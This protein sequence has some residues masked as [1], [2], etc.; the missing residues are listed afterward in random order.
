MA[1]VRYKIEEKEVLVKIVENAAAAAA[2]E[3]ARLEA[4]GNMT[5]DGIPF[6]DLT[7]SQAKRT[8]DTIDNILKKLRGEFAEA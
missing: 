2:E 6:S 3:V 5:P 8:V 4:L 1:G 7:I